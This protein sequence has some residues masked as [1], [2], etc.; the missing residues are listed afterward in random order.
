M[1]G[2]NPPPPPPPHP[3][4]TIA[5][6]NFFK[7]LSLN[8]EL[9]I[10]RKIIYRRVRINLNI[11]G[12]ILISRFYEQFSRYSRN[13]GNFLEIWKNF[14]LLKHKHMIYHFEAIDLEIPNI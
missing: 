6:N 3:T 5:T 11:G 12:N 9:N 13:L 7:D 14:E 8:L 10:I 1:R 4:T 2:T